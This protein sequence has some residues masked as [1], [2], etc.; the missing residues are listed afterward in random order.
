MTHSVVRFHARIQELMDSIKSC[1]ELST[2]ERYVCTFHHHCLLSN[3]SSHQTL[4][5][6]TN[7]PYHVVSEK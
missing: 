4:L 2:T 5:P 7:L 3:V 1:L 6:V